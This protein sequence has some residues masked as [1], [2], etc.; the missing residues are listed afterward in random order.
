MAECTY[1]YVECKKMTEGLPV[2]YRN[3][4]LPCRNLQL[5]LFYE[6]DRLVNLNKKELLREQERLQGKM[7]GTWE[8]DVLDD[9]ISEKEN[10][11]ENDFVRATP[12][13]NVQRSTFPKR[14]NIDEEVTEKRKGTESS[15]ER[16]HGDNEDDEDH[17]TVIEKEKVKRVGFNKIYKGPKRYFPGDKWS[18]EF[19]NVEKD[20]PSHKM[21]AY[22]L[23]RRRKVI[24]SKVTNLR[25]KY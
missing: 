5:R 13:Q 15:N 12:Q 8:E 16:E 17:D 24:T 1:E 19:E 11:G 23:Y 20:S 7:K 10:I 6:K 21:L 14:R 9:D 4:C 2:L 3:S 22:E 18:Y 25:R